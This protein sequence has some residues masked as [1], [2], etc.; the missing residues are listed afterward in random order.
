M[1]KTIHILIIAILSTSCLSNPKYNL[2]EGD[3]VLKGYFYRVDSTK[4]LFIYHF[5]SD[6]ID[7]VF[8][9]PSKKNI[10]KN[11][12]TN[13]KKIKINN[14]YKLVLSKQL[15]NSINLKNLRE[16]IYM[17]SILIWDTNMKKEY[18]LDCKNIEGDLINEKFTIKK[19]QVTV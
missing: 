13:Y 14:N 9:K 5:K 12:V 3:V 17:D 16:S 7:G 15:Y 2:D 8:A 18:F 19:N 6:S 1:R 4:H 10:K 11:Q